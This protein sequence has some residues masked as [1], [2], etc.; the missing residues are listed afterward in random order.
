M[1]NSLDVPRSG[2]EIGSVQGVS[3]Y[4]VILQDTYTI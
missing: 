4:M 3:T 1:I 2:I